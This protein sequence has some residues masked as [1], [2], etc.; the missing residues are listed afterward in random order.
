MNE[1]IHKELNQINIPNSLHSRCEAGF[2]EAMTEQKGR[3]MMFNS[4]KK[5]LA[6][7]IA[8]VLMVGVIGTGTAFADSI[9]GFFTDVKNPTGAI[10]GTRYNNATEEITVTAK[11]DSEAVTVHLDFLFPNE[12]P[13]GFISEVSVKNVVITGSNGAK[14][15]TVDETKRTVITDGTASISI[16]L[17]T[18]QLNTNTEYTIIFDTVVGHEKADQPLP[19]GGTWRCTFTIS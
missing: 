17:G 15:L 13:Y 1:H 16:P 8:L 19:M 9:R 12:A 18:L 4:K 10:I 11:A 5:A 14:L 3:I 2:N 6:A 7:A